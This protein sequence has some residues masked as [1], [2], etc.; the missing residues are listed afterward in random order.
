MV[1]ISSDK[2]RPI[3]KG[4]QPKSMRGS[5]YD[6]HV[7][8]AK[9]P[10]NVNAEYIRHFTKK[11]EVV[12]D[13]FVG[14]GVTAAEALKL[15]RKAIAIDLNPLSIFITKMITVSPVDIDQFTETF[16]AIREKVEERIQSY[17]ITKCDTCGEEIP[18]STVYYDYEEPKRVIYKCRNCNRRGDRAPFAEDLTK[19]DNVKEEFSEVA[20]RN[21]YILQA[22]KTKLIENP[23]KQ[24]GENE[25][26]ADL[27]T[28]RNLLSL[29]IL[30]DAIEELQDNIYKA[31][32]KFV[33]GSRL[34]LLKKDYFRSTSG[35]AQFLWVPEVNWVERNVWTKF[36]ETF[37]QVRKAKEETNNLIGTFYREA[38]DFRDL[39]SDSTIFFA[40]QDA[41]N[42]TDLI[43]NHSVDYVLTDPPYSDQVVY[44]EYTLLWKPWFEYHLDFEKEIVITD[45]PVRHEKYK[46]SERSLVNYRQDLKNA[47]SEIHRTLRPGGWA[48]IW[49]RCKEPEIWKALTDAIDDA[50][51]ERINVAQQPFNVPTWNRGINPNGTLSEYIILNCRKTGNVKKIR[52]VPSQDEVE[53]IFIG[54]AT[55]EIMR[56]A[57]ADEPRIWS[58]FVSRFLTDYGIP[59]PEGLDFRHLLA[60]HFKFN[61][62]EGKYYLKT[63]RPEEDPSKLLKYVKGKENESTG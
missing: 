33:F 47:F 34:Q 54:V 23:R 28:E 60:K 61:E 56:G 12:M 50:K 39:E 37:N 63:Y 42:L 53:N 1:H 27:F 62:K 40:N 10:Y 16:N 58:T 13:P 2:F 11:D 24:I 38:K 5:I 46:G 4:I 41:R 43:P 59:P 3:E 44:F 6:S 15:R 52:L 30:F 19:I 55:K 36:E 31:L 29:C 49:F 25:Y 22:Q 26:V 35:S 51:L 14:V 7:Y 18:F 17:Y 8:W 48:S 45:S 9:K 57:G 20:L 21:K 32:L